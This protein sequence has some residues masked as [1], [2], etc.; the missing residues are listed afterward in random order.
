MKLYIVTVLGAT[1]KLY[2]VTI[3]QPNLYIVTIPKS[4]SA[5]RLTPDLT[6]DSE[7]WDPGF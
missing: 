6:P 1:F 2:I 5:L 3:P 4:S 7:I